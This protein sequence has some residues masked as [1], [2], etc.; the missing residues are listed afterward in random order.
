MLLPPFIERTVA[1][2]TES[3]YIPSFAMWYLLSLFYYRMMIYCFHAKLLDKHPC[4]VLLISIVISLLGGFLPIEGTFSIQRTLTF[5]P[6]FF[7]G[8]YSNRIDVR[9]FVRKINTLLA[10]AILILIFIITYFYFNYDLSFVL[11]GT[12]SYYQEGYEPSLLLLGRVIQIVLAIIMSMCVIRL[13]NGNSL[14]S[15]FG[16]NTM[17]IYIYHTFP[18]LLFIYCMN[19]CYLPDKAAFTISYTMLTV[20]VLSLLSKMK[21]FHILLNPISNLILNQRKLI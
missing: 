2:K 14:L 1:W 4:T 7:A 10:I 8:Y 21:L 13:L 6:F 12:R 20:I 9:Y 16:K 15:K 18:T 3:P 17:I 5:I 11:Y 19:K